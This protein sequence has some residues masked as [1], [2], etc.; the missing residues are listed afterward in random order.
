VNWAAAAFSG[1][2]SLVCVAFF[3]PV[4]STAACC[5]GDSTSF[6][7]EV[8]GAA[9]LGGFALRACYSGVGVGRGASGRVFV[10]GPCAAVGGGPAI[11]LLLLLGWLRVFKGCYTGDVIGVDFFSILGT[12]FVGDGR[13]LCRGGGG[14]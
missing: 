11:L 12:T 1:V 3:L 6:W 9:G 14:C 7:E 2:L 4:V 8:G 5:P 10:F 13:A